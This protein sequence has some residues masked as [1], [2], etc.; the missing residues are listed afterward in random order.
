MKMTMVIGVILIVLGVA[1][2]GYQGVAL[3]TTHDTVAQM[4]PVEAKADSTHAIPLAPILSGAALVG[5][6]A[7]LIFGANKRSV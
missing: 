6:L 1:A 2:L 3:I 4:G 7:L 5:G